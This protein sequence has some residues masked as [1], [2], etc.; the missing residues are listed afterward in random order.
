[1]ANGTHEFNEVVVQIAARVVLPVIALLVAVG[2]AVWGAASA[3]EI[4]T[5]AIVFDTRAWNT[6]LVDGEGKSQPGH[7]IRVVDFGLEEGRGL[8]FRTERLADKVV[9][10]VYVADAWDAIFDCELERRPIRCRDDRQTPLRRLPV[11]E[12]CPSGECAPVEHGGMTI[13]GDW[14]YVAD[15]HQRKVTMRNLAD[16]RLGTRTIGDGVV[17][18][19]HDVVRV[20]S[21]GQVVA[22]SAVDD[23]V[24]LA[25]DEKA[26]P[27]ETEGAVYEL[28]DAGVRRN[29][30]ARFTHPV[31]LAY[32]SL[33]KR[34]YVVD[35]R[36]RTQTWRYFERV[37][38]TWR[39]KGVLWSETI[40]HAERWPRLQSM[41]IGTSVAN[42]EVVFAAG[43]DGLYL[44]HA[45]GTLLA[46]YLLGAPV[47]GLTWGRN[48]E[49]FMTVER[50][51]CVLQ[52]RARDGG[53]PTDPLLPLPSTP[54]PRPGPPR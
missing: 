36:G 6:L 34:L 50:R 20:A 5:H 47:S 3:H 52:T 15:A 11:T 23:G 38:T 16:P 45:D 14:L 35:V 10:H 48:G 42:E 51:L 18:R 40:A 53:V 28:S 49:L 1:M 26:D 2:V 9:E 7:R 17:R 37:E 39:E 4:G 32:S 19:I 22:E 54:M 12:I 44:F 27:A 24:V 46:K 8:A 31:G 25:R 30:E 43:P 29:I 33:R 13:G 21:N 41:A